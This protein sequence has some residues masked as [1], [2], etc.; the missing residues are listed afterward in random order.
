MYQYFWRKGTTGFIQGDNNSGSNIHC[1]K[2]SNPTTNSILRPRFP[3]HLFDNMNI[4]KRSLQFIFQLL[5]AALPIDSSPGNCTLWN[6]AYV[7]RLSN[8]GILDGN[9][10]TSPPPKYSLEQQRSYKISVVTICYF[11]FLQV[12]TV[13]MNKHQHPLAKQSF[14]TKYLF[15]N[16]Y[17]KWLRICMAH[18]HTVTH[19][20]Y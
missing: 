14:M 1:F 16:F 8:S 5:I 4:C 6:S 7:S 12:K 3:C 2:V 19:D 20:R 10:T 9:L 17:S 11:M 18:K 15:I 13:N